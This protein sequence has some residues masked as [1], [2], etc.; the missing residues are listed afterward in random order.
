VGTTFFPQ[1]SALLYT[2]LCRD[3]YPK[4]DVTVQIWQLSVLVEN[5]WQVTWNP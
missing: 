4:G 3:S 1:S 2:L 5:T